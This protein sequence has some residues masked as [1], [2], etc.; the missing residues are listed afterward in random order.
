M[1]PEGF[2]QSGDIPP[3]SFLV[4]DD[5]KCTAKYVE[6]LIELLNPIEIVANTRC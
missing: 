3:T 4:L 1:R 5:N 6:R 2:K